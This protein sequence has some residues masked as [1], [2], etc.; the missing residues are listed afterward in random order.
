MGVA[1]LQSEHMIAQKCQRHHGRQNTGS[2]GGWKTSAEL[3]V[4]ALWTSGVSQ[5]SQG[6]CRMLP[7]CF[8]AMDQG[9]KGCVRH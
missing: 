7:D 8:G 4:A 9:A 1:A 2:E 3:T 5:R 6:V